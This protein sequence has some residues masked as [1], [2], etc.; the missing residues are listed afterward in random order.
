[1]KVVDLQEAE[2]EICKGVQADTFAVEWKK[3]K[4]GVIVGMPVDRQEAAH[5]RVKLRTS[6]RFCGLDPFLDASDINRLAGVF[7]MLAYLALSNTLL[8]YLRKATLLSC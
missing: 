6:S 8:S 1:M 5:C 2:F 4:V 7:R 3:L